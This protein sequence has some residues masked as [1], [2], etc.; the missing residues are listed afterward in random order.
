VPDLAVRAVRPAV[1][2]A[3]DH[4]RG[5]DPGPDRDHEHLR[6]APARAQPGF[7][8][9]TG[10]HVVSEHRGQA[11]PLLDQGAQRHVAEAHI[12]RIAR[13]PVLLVDDPR[14]HDPDRLRRSHFRQSTRDG[15][16]RLDHRLRPALPAG[17]VPLGVQHPVILADQGALHSGAAHVDRDDGHAV[18][19]FV[20]HS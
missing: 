15:Q 16:D 1:D 9:P 18:T 7:R 17:R 11:Q 13:D 12:G 19:S 4:V 20:G 6:L 5:G 8:E 2:H 10:P 3:V 14:H